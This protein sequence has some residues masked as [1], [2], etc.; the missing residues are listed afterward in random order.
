MTT[1]LKKNIKTCQKCQRMPKNYKKCKLMV[2]GSQI[3][4]Q[5]WLRGG[6][7]GCA[8]VV[9]GGRPQGHAHPW[10]MNHWPLIID[11]LMNSSI[12]YYRCSILMKRKL[13][14]MIIKASTHLF[15][16]LAIK[17]TSYQKKATPIV[18]NPKTWFVAGPVCP[19]EITFQYP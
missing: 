12:I 8:W 4:A 9:K 1:H 5:G 19:V 11:W 18:N 7:R 2:G 16:P 10:A 15:E 13:R 17:N 3:M 14:W 6:W